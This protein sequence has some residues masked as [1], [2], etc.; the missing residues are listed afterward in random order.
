MPLALYFNEAWGD[1]F[2]TATAA[3]HAYAQA[4]NYVLLNA[5]E[6]YVVPNA[7]VLTQLFY[8]GVFAR[9]MDAH[10]LDFYWP[11]IVIVARCR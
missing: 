3:G 2:S 1:H 6:A 10:P 4:N 7:T 9:I 5:A 11:A 8:Q